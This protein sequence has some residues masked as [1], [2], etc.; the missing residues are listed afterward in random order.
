MEI[1][2]KKDVKKGTYL[3]KSDLEE[4][5]SFG[6]NST[7]VRKNFGTGLVSIFSVTS[8]SQSEFLSSPK[9]RETDEAEKSWKTQ[10]SFKFDKNFFSRRHDAR[11]RRCP[12]KKKLLS[13]DDKF[14]L[15]SVCQVQQHNH[16]HHCPLWYTRWFWALEL[17]AS[18]KEPGFESCCWKTM[19]SMK[20]LIWCWSMFKW[21]RNDYLVS[22]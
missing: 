11:G 12:L 1:R 6:G 2:I 10:P 4:I 20:T 9:F 14:W 5:L 22:H 13:W 21:L 18:L 17:V 19:V 8:D 16:I 7:D 3:K 15:E